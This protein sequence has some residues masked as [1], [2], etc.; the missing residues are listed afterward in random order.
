MRTY[1][2]GCAAAHALD[3]IGERWA[4]L[5]VRE[6]LLGPKRFTDL[7]VG[8]PTASP[9]VLAQRLRE[10]ER[11][12][13]VRR[14]KL[15][16][17]AASR[18]YELTEWGE[19]LE[20][21]IISLG[22]WGARSPSRLRDAELG[23]DSIILSFRTMFDPGVAEGLEAVYELRFGEERFR[24]EVRDGR[25]EVERGSVE[26]RLDAIIEADAP[27]LAE[28]VYEGRSLEEALGSGEVRIEGE[29]EAVERFVGLFPLPE[30]AAPAVGA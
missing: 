26:K 8:L 28:V 10:L 16:P 27:T 12:G 15:P 24:A 2:D 29:R 4:L 7:R 21:V 9:N 13:I 11:A 6:L 20:P 25:F 1:C 5:V 23:V 22:R 18:V 30:P 17:P 19:E 3:L 14:R